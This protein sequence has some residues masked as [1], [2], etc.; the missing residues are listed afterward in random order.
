MTMTAGSLAPVWKTYFEPH[1]KSA[2]ISPFG[3]PENPKG[4][5]TL[6]LER[7]SEGDRAAESALLPRVYSELHRLA[8]SRM[9]GERPDHTL[10][11]TALVHEVYIR[12]CGTNE[13]DW[14]N[15]R[16]FFCLAGRLMRR[17]LVDHARQ[18]NA[19]KRHS[20]QRPAS[21]DDVIVLSEDQSFAAIEVD[22]VLQELAKIS[23]RQAQVV[24]MRFFAGLSEDEIA[25]AIGKNV[26]TV[27]RDWLMARAWLHQRLQ[28][29]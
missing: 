14:Q 4:E 8:L 6:L 25:E 20:G 22:E 28:P 29:K 18:H 10:Q 24:E 11:A 13:I 5:I 21:I 27:K 2:I 1:S 19:G 9:S 7:L 3:M 16:H 26:R 23:P 15:R 12:L 17:I